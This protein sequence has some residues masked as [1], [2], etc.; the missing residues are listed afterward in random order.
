M[1]LDLYVAEDNISAHTT[2]MKAGFWCLRTE[3]RKLKRV[4]EELTKLSHAMRKLTLHSRIAR[5]IHSR[6]SERVRTTTKIMNQ[7]RY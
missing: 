6:Q 7:N 4:K 1:F 3:S 2:S 5:S